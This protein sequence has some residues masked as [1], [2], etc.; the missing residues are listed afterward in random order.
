MADAEEVNEV[1]LELAEALAEVADVAE[2][3]P[4][5]MTSVTVHKSVIQTLA[6]AAVVC[7]SKM[8]RYKAHKAFSFLG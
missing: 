8:A 3:P 6:V 2:V 1:E 7:L 5:A 4:L